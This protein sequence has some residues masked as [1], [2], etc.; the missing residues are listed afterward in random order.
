MR[1]AKEGYNVVNVNYALYPDSLNQIIDALDF[2]AVNSEEYRID[3]DKMIFS[4]DSTGE[5]LTGQLLLVL[6]DSEYQN[7]IGINL[8]E[9]VSQNFPPMF[10]SDGN[11]GQF[12][13]QAKAFSSQLDVLNVF[14]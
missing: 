14:N 3:T 10:I 13:E 1:Y 2:V 4:G 5:Q 12:T 9:N 7:E 11:F 8:T 6:T